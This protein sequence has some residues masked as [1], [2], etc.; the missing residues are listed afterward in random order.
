MACGVVTPTRGTRRDR[1][2]RPREASRTRAKAKLGLVPQDLAIYEELS[3]LQNLRYFGALYGLAATELAARIDWALERRRAARARD[4]A[5][6]A[7]LGRHEAAAQPRRRARCTSRSC[8]CSTSRPS[9]SIRRAATTSSR[10]CSALRA[11]GMTDHLHEPL[12]G[13]GRGA[14]RSRRDHRS[15][16]RSSRPGTVAELIAQHAGKGVELELGGDDRCGARARPRRTARSKRDGAHAD[17]SCRRR[18]S[19]PVIA[20]IEAAGATIARIE[21]RQANLETVFLALTGRAL[22]DA[23]MIGAAIQQ[24]RPAAAARPRRC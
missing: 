20:A 24:G 12:H 4:R 10:P 21:S 14:V 11:D 7:L 18:G 2:H 9:A 19:A 16:A 3:A 5:G 17:A 22:R 15:T 6:E 8:S 1:R 23:S 13:R